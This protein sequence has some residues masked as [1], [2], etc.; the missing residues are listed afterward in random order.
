M[1]IKKLHIKGFRNF[2]DVEIDFQNKTLVIGA[3]DVGK[4]NLLYALRLLFD[5]TISEHDL[6]LSESDFN[7]YSESDTIEI[8][9][10]LCEI[11]EECLIS[12]FGGNI[13]DGCTIIRYTNK[14]NTGYEIFVGY[15]EDTLS[16]IQ[17]RK[18]IKRL[19]MQYVDTNRD[20]FSFLRRERI[21]MLQISKENLTEK[22]RENDN[23]KI[24]QIQTNLDC[25][26]SEISSLKYISNSLN[27]VNKELGELSAHNEDQDVRFVAGES[28]ADKLL[29]NLVLAYSTENNPL[30]IGGD[31]RNNQIFLATWI[32]KQH[33]IESADHVTFYA[34]EEPEAHLHP[35]QQRKLSSYI[36]QS[37]DS[38]VIIT[39]HSPH[40]ASKFNPDSIVRLY[41]NNKNTI[42]ACGG[43]S[44]ML[45]KVFNEFNYRLNSLSA[46]MLFSDGVFLVEG[47]SEVMFYTS[48]ANELKLDIDRYN[49]SIV[50]V[51]GVGFKPYIAIC[52]AL[53]IPWT[54]R[55]DND[56][57]S[58]PKKNP[59]KNYY[60]GLS[61]TISIIESINRN[62]YI[63][64]FWKENS[65]KNE[66]PANDNIPD[67]AQEMNAYLKKEV[68]N[69]N[70]FLSDDDL[71]N[72][73]ANS[74]IS[75]DLSKYFNEE[76]VNDLVAKMQNRKAENMYNFLNN[77]RSKL[78]KLDGN[79]ITTPLKKIISIV[80]KK[81]RPNNDENAN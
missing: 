81:M 11:T 69:F 75:S 28:K 18:Y 51:E 10:T 3:N 39:T 63:L 9:A 58:K 80:T 22:E 13:K 78:I 56:I 5:K 47:T 65:D 73:L 42:A 35:H 61:R 8:T 16:K 14:K 36:Q 19:N 67:E 29:D 62:N 26:N 74:E 34:I 30:S 55:T 43:C 37:F 27:E 24:L 1:R 38:Q 54:L 23:Q 50:S 77:N 57:F 33:I 66:W 59:T 68:E 60:S 21:K 76:V 6:E 71:E 45:K 53:S 12:E 17:T 72:D 48:L 64:D 25:I 7:A 4:T 49:I 15:C 79:R 20:L 32:A 44:E 2:S 40:I 52:N 46:E 31:G 70:I 41:A